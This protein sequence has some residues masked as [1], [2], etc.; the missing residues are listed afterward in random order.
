M[1]ASTIAAPDK[2]LADIL[3]DFIKGLPRLGGYS[4]ILVVVDHLSKYG[5]FIQLTHPFKTKQMA[6]QFV[7]HVSEHY[8]MPESIVIVQGSLFLV[9]FERSY[10]NYKVLP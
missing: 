10:L 9:L 8:G 1:I 5:Y 6:V 2:V 4:S 7:H 3:M